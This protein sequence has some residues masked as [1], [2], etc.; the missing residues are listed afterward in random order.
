MTYKVRIALIVDDICDG[1]GTF[2]GLAEELK[3]K[4]AGKI[5]LAVSHG[6]FSK[7]IDKLD[8]LAHVYATDAYNTQ[9]HELLTQISLGDGLLS[10]Y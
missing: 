5:Y 2:I 10:G 8:F 1:G 9:A 4:N 7:G 3:R 6:I